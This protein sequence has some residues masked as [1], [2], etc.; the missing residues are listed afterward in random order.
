M[1]N[2]SLSAG[3]MFVVCSTYSNILVICFSMRRNNT[4]IDVLAQI[5]I[6]K[7]H[8]AKPTAVKAV[9]MAR[10]QKSAPIATDDA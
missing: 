4:N 7:D 3:Q 6:V 5:A 1:A 2:T 10:P 8:D 9:N